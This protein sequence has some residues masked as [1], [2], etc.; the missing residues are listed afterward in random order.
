VASAAGLVG[1]FCEAWIEQSPPGRGGH[2]ECGAQTI[3]RAK[4][5]WRTS[6]SP[7]SLSQLHTDHYIRPL[8]QVGFRGVLLQRGGIMF[9]GGVQPM[10]WFGIFG[11]RVAFFFSFSVGGFGGGG[12]VHRLDAFADG[13]PIY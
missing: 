4:Q 8:A 5:P 10:D 1:C 12:L 13:V 2:V 6:F 3:T 9:G 11:R 7:S